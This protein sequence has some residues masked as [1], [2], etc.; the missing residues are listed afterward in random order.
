[1]KILTKT[2]LTLCQEPKHQNYTL[3]FNYLPLAS[4]VSLFF[5][6]ISLSISSWAL[7]E[8]H[9][10]LN[11]SDKHTPLRNQIQIF[12]DPSQS[13]NIKQILLDDHR[14]QWK[15]NLDEIPN[16]GFTNAA[17][18][19]LV[20]LK[21]D[22]DVPIK[23]ILEID[24]PA[25]DDIHFFVV[26]ENQV[27]DDLH[28]GDN[29][30]FNQRRVKHR[31]F[32]L[33]FEIPAHT[34]RTIIVRVVTQ[35]SMQIPLDLWKPE[36]F[37]E[38]DQLLLF[39][40]AI[41]IG[42]MIGL[43]GYNLILFLGIRDVSYLYYVLFVIFFSLTQ[44]SVEGLSSQFLWPNSVWWNIRSIGFLSSGII[45]FSPLFALH[46]LRLRHY[47]PSMA[48]AA[49]FT[50]FAGIFCIL[51]TLIA[52]YSTAIRLIVFFTTTACIIAITSG[53]T[54]WKKGFRPARTYT[55][56]WVSLLVGSLFFTLSKFG[57][58]P[59]N[60][61]F[62]YS[63]QIGSTLEVF[64][65]SLALGER[66]NRERHLRHKLQE[67]AIRREKDYHNKIE[68]ISNELENKIEKETQPSD[69]VRY[70]KSKIK[71]L[72]VES[73]LL[74]IMEL[75]ESNKLFK[76][77]DLSLQE[78]S[79]KLGITT[80]QLS[81]ILNEKTGK[82]FNAFINHYRVG[83]AKTSLLDNKEKPI[84]DIGFDSGFNSKSSFNTNF[85]KIVG[86][87]PSQFREDNG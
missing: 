13:L 42:I 59:R 49:I 73:T 68:T 4:L 67:I 14:I 75:M 54:V 8:T 57:V 5:F 10:S 18:W 2:F 37:F 38:K 81:Q 26:S 21:N 40:Q 45:V 76:N 36:K 27:I 35:G 44:L 62:E 32:L 60:F 6:T 87:T 7:T 70:K 34:K 56:A 3:R 31:N 79:T 15:D 51:L 85:Y 64:L 1:M 47:N 80:H 29:F 24:H 86:A 46:F 30:S 28:T 17:V 20:T 11:L 41:Y 69:N 33:P 83:D 58:L 43:A 72:D 25:L 9:I 55:I 12:V 52:T 48:K 78:F 53:I 16:L 82:N 23:K 19:I 39:I 22:N 65:L 84:I 61:V 63:S 66:I 74:Q 50:T 71:D 77:P